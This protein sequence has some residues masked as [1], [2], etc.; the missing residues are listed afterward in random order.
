MNY[1]QT[2]DSQVLPGTIYYFEL[3]LRDNINSGKI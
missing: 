1:G 3:R 2:R